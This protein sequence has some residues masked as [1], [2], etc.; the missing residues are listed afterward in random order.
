MPKEQQGNLPIPDFSALGNVESFKPFKPGALRRKRTLEYREVV[1]S[2]GTFS[3]GTPP[4]KKLNIGKSGMTAESPNGSQYT[5]SKILTTPGKSQASVFHEVTS[6]HNKNKQ[7]RF[8]LFASPSKKD[9]VR[10]EYDIHELPVVKIQLKDLLKFKGKRKT[11]KYFSEAKVLEIKSATIGYCEQMNEQPLRP[12]ECAHA[13]AFMFG[14]INKI[15]PNTKENLWLSSDYAN[16]EDMGYEEIIRYFLTQN[17][18]DYVN[19]QVTVY[20]HKNTDVSCMK[21]ITL[22]LPTNNEEFT[23]TYHVDTQT[24]NKPSREQ[25]SFFF[26]KM[27]LRW[28]KEKK[29]HESLSAF[30]YISGHQPSLV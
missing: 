10:A 9:I 20:T 5:A 28:V 14:G 1:I 11:G 17:I 6:P 12:Q 29:S 24:T 7:L 8:G 23:F 21:K 18:I 26:A 19:M 4:Q 2:T 16:T 15:N 22:S 25:E 13:Y 30:D 3:N 27:F